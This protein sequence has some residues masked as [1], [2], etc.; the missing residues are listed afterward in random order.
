MDDAP[1]FPHLSATMLD[2]EMDQ[3]CIYFLS[4]MTKESSDTHAQCRPDNCI[5]DTLDTDTYIT[6]HISECPD[7]GECND[8]L[9]DVTEW[10]PLL[11]IVAERQVPLLTVLERNISGDLQVKVE[12]SKDY[13]TTSNSVC[14]ENSSMIKRYVCI[15]YVWSDQV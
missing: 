13:C 2:Q 8:V 9:L 14:S 7:S 1:W 11:D 3:S 6:Q 12:R 15:S 5:L 4:R 10:T